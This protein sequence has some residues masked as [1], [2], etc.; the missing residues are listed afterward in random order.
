M[1]TIDQSQQIY[2]TITFSGGTGLGLALVNAIAT[3]HEALLTLEDNEPGL[4]VSLV[5]PRV[6]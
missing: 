1:K 6:A 3:R 5:F 4:R 2:F